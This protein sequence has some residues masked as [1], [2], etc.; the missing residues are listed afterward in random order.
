MGD[1]SLI[2]IMY[3][4]INTCYLQ[5]F[6]GLEAVKL[7]LVDEGLEVMSKPSKEA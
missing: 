1:T 6:S 4:A 2:F 3:V 5:Q 7:P